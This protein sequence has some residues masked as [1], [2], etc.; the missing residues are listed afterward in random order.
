MSL[1]FSKVINGFLHLRYRIKMHI[2]NMT[3]RLMC[4][5]VQM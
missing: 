1:L 5:L 3:C 4:E 2:V